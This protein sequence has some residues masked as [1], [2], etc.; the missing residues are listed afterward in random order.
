M[1]DTVT[2]Q[3]LETLNDKTSATVTA[4]IQDTAA[5]MAT[6]ISRGAG[7]YGPLLQ[8]ATK[9]QIPNYNGENLADL[10]ANGL[11]EG[12]AYGDPTLELLM[13]QTQQSHMM[14]LQSCLQLTPLFL[15]K[16]MLM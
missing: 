8:Q 4:T 11:V 2:I 10:G 12:G 15:H 3:E 5:N 9:T 16:T 1:T 14:K 7:V 6:L 13:T